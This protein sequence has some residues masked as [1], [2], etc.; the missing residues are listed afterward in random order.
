MEADEGDF[1]RGGRGPDMGQTE[2]ERALW[3]WDE[4]NSL[5]NYI[6]ML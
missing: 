4:S 5:K 2:Q 1:V 6:K 3:G